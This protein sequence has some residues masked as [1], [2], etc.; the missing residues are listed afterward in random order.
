MQ[1]KLAEIL[2][3]GSNGVIGLNSFDEE[4]PLLIFSRIIKDIKDQLITE[5]I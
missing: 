5:F 1:N 4:N 2:W 3:E